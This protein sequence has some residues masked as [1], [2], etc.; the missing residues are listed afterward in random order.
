M[1]RSTPRELRRL[2]NPFRRQR[3]ARL[4]QTECL[5][6]CAP[7]LCPRCHSPIVLALRLVAFPV[8]ASTVL[9][10]ALSEGA[11]SNGIPLVGCNVNL[12]PTVSVCGQVRPLHDEP[13][14][15]HAKA[16]WFGDMRSYS[17]AHRVLRLY[18]QHLRCASCSIA[19]AA[20]Q[21]TYS[22]ANAQLAWVSDHRVPAW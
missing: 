17:L 18:S 13:C 8:R 10:H 15:T 11:D 6:S 4:G 20:V 5:C 3:R 14:S 2:G 19:L 16:E 7:A 12:T 1:P 9:T 21:P 22:I